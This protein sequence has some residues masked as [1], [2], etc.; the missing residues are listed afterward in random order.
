MVS[1]DPGTAQQGQSP[2]PIARSRHTAK[3]RRYLIEGSWVVLVGDSVHLHEGVKSAVTVLVVPMNLYKKIG[4]NS[5]ILNRSLSVWKLAVFS[6]PPS[7]EFYHPPP[8]PPSP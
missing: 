8:P 5:L 6:F 1:K 7:P 4:F 2:F 3:P